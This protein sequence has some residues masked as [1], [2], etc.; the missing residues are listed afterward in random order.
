MNDNERVTE[1][2]PVK[3]PSVHPLTEVP[4]T[5]G[6]KIVKDKGGRWQVETPRDPKAKS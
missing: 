1:Q 6:S 4:L 2:V 3:E 5:D